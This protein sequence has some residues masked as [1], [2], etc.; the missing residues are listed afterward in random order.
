MI[1]AANSHVETGDGLAIKR[2]THFSDDFL[3]SLACE[4]SA[5]AGLRAAETD[6]VASIP[7]QVVDV[8]LR[9]GFDVYRATPKA[10]LAR[11]RAENLHAFI[12]TDKSL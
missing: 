12:T 2:V 11:L 10:I 7:T 8:W 3:S 1:E 9:Q 6:R 5:K 4:R